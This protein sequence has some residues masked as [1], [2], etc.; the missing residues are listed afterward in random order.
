MEGC[1]WT[2]QVIAL[3]RLG[4]AGIIISV[5]DMP[6]YVLFVGVCFSCCSFSF[7]NRIYVTSWSSRNGGVR[8]YTSLPLVFTSKSSYVRA[9]PVSHSMLLLQGLQS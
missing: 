6:Q 4:A 2:V 7:L 8:N 9:R 5:P 3:E 1:F